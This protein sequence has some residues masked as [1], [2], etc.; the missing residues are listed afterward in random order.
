LLQ[1][2]FEQSLPFNA[3]KNRWFDHTKSRMC[4][5][6]ISKDP[7]G[8]MFGKEHPGRVRGLSVGACPTV[9]FQ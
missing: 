3:G 7:I 5:T 4:L 9:A 8:V 2:K 1:N 6:Y